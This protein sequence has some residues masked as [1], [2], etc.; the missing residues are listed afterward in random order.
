MIL[1]PE[2][3]MQFVNWLENLRVDLTHT[4]NGVRLRGARPVPVG[5]TEGAQSNPTYSPGRLCGFAL[6]NESDDDEASVSVLFYD[7]KT[8]NADKIMTVTLAPG[9]SAREWYGDGI[10]LTYGLFLEVDG[11]VSGSVFLGED[12]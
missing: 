3:A 1:P 7:G 8:A 9:E 6:K 5:I 4:L 12:S 10:A 2:A 11:P